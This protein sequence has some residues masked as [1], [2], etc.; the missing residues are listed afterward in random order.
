MVQATRDEDPNAAPYSEDAAPT[1]AVVGAGPGLGA[2]V[3]RRFAAEGCR[4]GLFARSS[5]RLSTLEDAIADE[6]GR[7]VAVPTDVTDSDA[8]EH[9]FERLREAFGPVD[10][11]VSTLYAT[12]ASGG[13]PA[14]TAPS[15][16]RDALRVEVEGLYRCV[17]AAL[18]D[19]REGGREDTGTVILTNTEGARRG[20][21][22]SLAR[23]VARAGLASL[24]DALADA[25]RDHG[26]HVV[27]AQIDGWIA[28][29]PLR[30]A[31]PDRPEEQWI[32]PAGIATAYWNLHTQPPGAWT[33]ELNLGRAGD[34]TETA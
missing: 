13:T 33:S 31:F 19:L 23:S 17:D 8:V 4:V 3:A 12:D 14:E 6:G 7:A 32:S 15:D 27:H 21:S 25:E 24:A 5:E 11:L 16:L 34:G 28:T 10:C 30:E 2:S 26:V 9:G 1:V 20:D 22:G 18:P 29:P